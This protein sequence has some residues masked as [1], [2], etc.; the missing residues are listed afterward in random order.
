MCYIHGRD[1]KLSKNRIYSGTLIPNENTHKYMAKQFGSINVLH[2]FSL[3]GNIKT[4]RNLKRE[5]IITAEIM[6]CLKV[7]AAALKCCIKVFYQSV[8]LNVGR[9]EGIRCPRQTCELC[10]LTMYSKICNNQERLKKKIR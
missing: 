10:D 9:C 2:E 3:S 1:N 5:I 7:L 8:M 4:R 6:C